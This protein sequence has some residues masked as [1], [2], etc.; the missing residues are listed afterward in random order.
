MGL[1][2]MMAAYEKEIIKNAL[3]TWKWN[4]GRTAAALKINRKT[5]FKKIMKHGLDSTMTGH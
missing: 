2:A 5:L 4:R 1:S 3:I